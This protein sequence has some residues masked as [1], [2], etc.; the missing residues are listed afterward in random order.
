MLKY[1]YIFNRPYLIETILKSKCP[2][3][4]SI[5]IRIFLITSGHMAGLYYLALLE[6]QGG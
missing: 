6:S 5:K 1:F 3:Y 4:F 2:Y